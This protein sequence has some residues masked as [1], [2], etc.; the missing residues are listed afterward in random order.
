MKKKLLLFVLLSCYIFG[1]ISNTRYGPGLDIGSKGSGVFFNYLVGNNQKNLDLLCELRYF[2]IKGETE[3]IVYDY[4]TNQY[5]TISGQ[6]LILIPILAGVNYH[7]FAG[8]I[9]N[10]F[11]PFITFRGGTNLAIDGK[12]GDGSYKQKWSKAKTHW[13]MAGFI[14]A[15]IEFR[16]YNQSSIALHIGSDILKLSQKADEKDDYSGLLIHISF[17]KFIKKDY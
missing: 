14:G 5:V 9:A 16:W 12:E 2:D 11:S 8:Q 1:N 3:S 13:S 6:N 15:G 4:W 17:N 7:P 10:N